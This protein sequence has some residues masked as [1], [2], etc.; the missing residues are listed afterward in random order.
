MRCRCKVGWN[1][2]RDVRCEGC[3][4]RV[5]RERGY[6]QDLVHPLSGG[7]PAVP[8]GGWV[9]E[10]QEPTPFA[11]ANELPFI[12]GLTM[13]ESSSRLDP[14]GVESCPGAPGPDRCVARGRATL[15]AFWANAATRGIFGHT[16]HRVQCRMTLYF[17]MSFLSVLHAYFRELRIM[18]EEEDDFV[19]GG[20]ESSEAAA[21]DEDSGILTNVSTDPTLLTFVQDGQRAIV[22]FNSKSVPDEVCVAAYRNQL[23]KYVQDHD[24]KTLAFELAGIKI[25]P[26]G[27]L[28]LLVSLKKRGLEIELL[29]PAVDIVDV[30]RITR[31]LQMFKVLNAA[32]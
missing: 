14:N 29:N 5:L 26:S 6:G 15:P 12:R 22:G 8:K 3:L 21:S 20:L 10:R 9:A 27:M 24:C 11:P 25:L 2:W 7:G 4:A 1:G 19:L 18:P 32:K 30:L 13:L 16:L 28:G 31:L 17:F 23:I